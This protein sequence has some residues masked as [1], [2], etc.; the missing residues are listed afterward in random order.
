MDQQQPAPTEQHQAPD[1]PAVLPS[2]PEAKGGKSLAIALVVS[3]VFLLAAA[4]IAA[5]LMLKPSGSTTVN[6]PTGD[7]SGNVMKVSFVAPPDM[8]AAYAK[9]D[10]N[11]HAAQ[12]TFYDNN[13]S[14]CSIT[15]DVHPA[16]ANTPAKDVMLSVMNQDKDTGIAT[17][18]NAPAGEY[19]IA[20]TDNSHTYKF[21]SEQL[22]QDVNVP[23]V[24]FTKQ[25][26]VVAYKQFGAFV[27][28]IGYGCKA[29]SWEANKTELE[30]LIKTFKVKTEC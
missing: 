19:T 3:A 12:T 25:T 15:T 11:T 24:D 22:E 10:Q 9:R 6:Q 5:W 18:S 8:P 30:T 16:T 28:S 13:T 7:G 14:F 17:T 2:S 26:K 21:A 27:A 1:I 29:D 4:G 20:D 23:G